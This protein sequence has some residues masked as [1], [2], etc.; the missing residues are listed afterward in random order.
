M[1]KISSLLL[2]VLPLVG[3]AQDTW[4]PVKDVSL[5]VSPGSILDFS[6]LAPASVAITS[7]LIV[8]NGQF[9]VAS[10]PTV[11]K[12][13]LMASSG[14]DAATG[15]IPNKVTADAYIQQWKLHGYNMVR[16]HFVDAIL[17]NLRPGDF[18]FSPTQLDNLYY[19]LAQM[20]KAG[21]YYIMDVITS[22]NGGYGN[23]EKRWI[24]T[25]YL[26][27]R[28]FFDPEAQAH[29][30]KMVD[31]LYASI[32]P[33]TGISLLKDPALAGLILV[34][35]GG[36]VF[37]NRYGYSPGLTPLFNAWLKTKYGT[38]AALA[39]AWKTELKAAENFDNNTVALA[40]LSAGA[41]PRMS[42]TQRF[43]TDLEKSTADWM[44]AYLRQSLPNYGYKGLVTSYDAW[45]SSQATA[46]RSQFDWVDLHS[47]FAGAPSDFTTPGSTA[48]QESM[49]GGWAQYIVDLSTSRVYGKAFSVSEYGQI[50]WNKYRR[51]TGL[52]FSAMASFQEWSMIAQHAGAVTLSYAEP[53][54]RKD[55]IYPYMAG[56]DPIQRA[57]ET[58]AALL[59][60]RGD[61]APARHRYAIKMT[62]AMAL[63][64]STPYTNLNTDVRRVSMISQ[65]GV[66][67]NGLASGRNL[68]EAELVPNNYRMNV[69][70]QA[71]VNPAAAPAPLD[72]P[73]ASLLSTPP[74]VTPWVA[75]AESSNT[76]N[77]DVDTFNNRVTSMRK[78]AAAQDP[79]KVYTYLY[80]TANTRENV[81]GGLFQ[82]DTGQLNVD[83]GRK[84][85]IVNTPRTEGVVFATPEPLTIKS[86][87]VNTASGPAMISVSA[88]DGLPIGQSK[89][90]LVI[91]ATDAR[92]SN[93]KFSDPGETTLADLGTGP[94]VIKTGSINLT[95]TNSNA[96]T[97]K[98]YSN[99]LNGVR[100]DLIASTVSV[101]TLNF[102]L[103]T[104]KLTHGPTT[105]FEIVA[106]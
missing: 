9:A 76:G 49:I 70:Y 45:V 85:M 96:G 24:D 23:I 18:D 8:K 104:S 72:A 102:T 19:L 106:P 54:G 86:L 1:K 20:K 75:P 12:R 53:S 2:A 52:A 4:A 97:L 59:F 62:P 48:S 26:S 81:V 94:V 27:K 17:M 77:W 35:E 67:Y 98:V 73:A 90:M 16:L 89:R 41:G 22:G 68:Y 71:P 87:R 37:T 50:F 51:E 55:R 82:S 43:I 63:D 5:L 88:M 101:G 38:T 21:I 56:P 7:P 42:D 28:V 69:I 6:S 13:F 58:L 99:T 66:D 31:K 25:K 44:T 78:A 47:Y 95:L 29:W 92:N 3:V 33:Y 83:A 103:D 64:V 32:N 30:K 60:L 79:S 61:V 14:F 39:T 65:L 84:R 34:N 40:S 100:K 46:S 80:D 93:M 15:G 10:N 74:T 105:Y 36:L 11:P 91:Y 57:N